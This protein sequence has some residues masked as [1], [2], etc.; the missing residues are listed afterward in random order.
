MSIRIVTGD[1]MTAQDVYDI[2][3]IRDAVFSVEQQCDEEDVDDRDLLPT[4]THLWLADDKGPTSYLRSY[5]EDGVRHIGRVCTRKDQ[6]GKG[7]SGSLM[8][9]CHRLWG[10]EPIELNAQAYLEQWYGRYG[11]VR[12]GDN[13]MEA[14]IE[15]VP[16][17]RTPP[18]A[19]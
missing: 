7:L 17:R 1:Q 14:G 19:D 8:Q 10:D 5:V 9:E 12:T 15:H 11:Y 18:A 3:K 2:W 16:M 6:R 4:M 13:F